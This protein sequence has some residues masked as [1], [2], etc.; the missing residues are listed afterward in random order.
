MLSEQDAIVLFFFI[1]LLFLTA[2]EE[3]NE[4]GSTNIASHG[5]SAEVPWS[6]ASVEMSSGSEIT[7]QLIDYAEPSFYSRCLS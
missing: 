6:S 4:R 7:V 2:N 1:F 3:F 5:V